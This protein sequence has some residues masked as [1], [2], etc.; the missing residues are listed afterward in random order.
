MGSLASQSLPRALIDYDVSSWSYGVLQEA[1]FDKVQHFRLFPFS[2]GPSHLA[3]ITSVIKS[4]AALGAL[5]SIYL[6]SL[7]DSGILAANDSEEALEELRQVCGEK[8]IQVIFEEQPQDDWLDPLVSHEFWR[9]M[10]QERLK[11]E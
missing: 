1:I 11:E 9:R 8:G 7:V 5:R 3:G 4:A 10:K 2:A 6:N